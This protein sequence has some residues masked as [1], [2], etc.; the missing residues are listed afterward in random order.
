MG[1]DLVAWVEWE[2]CSLRTSAIHHSIDIHSIELKTTDINVQYF[3]RIGYFSTD[4]ELNVTQH[5]YVL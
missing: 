2:V 1:W 4:G 3:C 5:L